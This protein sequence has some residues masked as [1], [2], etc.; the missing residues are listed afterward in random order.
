MK[1]RIMITVA[2]RNNGDNIY[3]YYRED[4]NIYETEDAAELDQKVEEL[5]E[6]HIKNEISIVSPIDYV[7]DALIDVSDIYVNNITGELKD[8]IL[9]YN[10]SG[11]N[12]YSNEEYTWNMDYDGETLEIKSI[13]LSRNASSDEVVKYNSSSSVRAYI[14]KNNYISEIFKIK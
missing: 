3:K 10:M 7:I 2:N 12:L 8:G 6:T 1:Y 9:T 14:R 13:G 4:N 5:L 11:K